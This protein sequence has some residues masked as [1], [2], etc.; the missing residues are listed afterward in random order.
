MQA[1]HDAPHLVLHRGDLL[2]LLLQEARR[3]KI[4]LVTDCAV[5]NVNFAAC[6]VRTDSGKVFTGDVL[7]GADGEKSF[8]RDTLFG[9]NTSPELTGKLVYRLT[10]PSDAI[11]ANPNIRDLIEPAKITCWLGPNSHVVCYNLDSKGVCN[12][13]LTKSDD[14]PSIHRAPSPQPA[15]MEELRRFFSAWDERLR[16]VL[17]LAASA[18]YWPLL[19]SRGIDTWTHPCGSFILIGDAAHSMPPHL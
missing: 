19:R 13:V 8:V 15:P 2:A 7:I 10:I 16:G 4:E 5:S 14:N 18:L 12:V 6:T 11:A 3:L 1:R 17:E 9:R